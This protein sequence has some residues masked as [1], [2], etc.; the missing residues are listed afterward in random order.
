[1]PNLRPLLASCSGFWQRTT[2]VAQGTSRG[3]SIWGHLAFL[4]NFIFVFSKQSLLGQRRVCQ[5]LGALVP[6]GPPSS[7]TPQA[8]FSATTPWAAL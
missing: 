3:A 8:R 2:V 5:G 4:Q 7:P 6:V 1:M